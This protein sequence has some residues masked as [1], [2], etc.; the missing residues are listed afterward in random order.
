M[1]LNCDEALEPNEIR[2]L[3]HAQLKKA[4]TAVLSAEREEEPS[5]SELLNEIRQI[6]DTLQEVDKIKAE[7]KCISEQLES[8]FQII[9]NQQL[10]LESI[11]NRERRNKL[12]ITGLSE[13]ADDRGANDSE[14]LTNVL[15]AANCP[16]SVN[17][18]NYTLRRLGEQN[19]NRPRPLLVTVDAPLQRDLVIE[20]AKNLRNAGALYS[21]IYINKDIHPVVRK[22][23]GRLRK[24]EKDE[25]AKPENARID[26]KYDSKNR[27]LLKENI[28][29]DRFSPKYF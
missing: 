3:S 27:V 25:K 29:I 14:K 28:I 2:S 20:H 6:K 5:N 23:I 13:T 7:V 8:A 10:F 4:L 11:D 1:P 19:E 12:V 16:G 9:H 15:S 22:E 24:R 18:S 26:I 21:R 17:S